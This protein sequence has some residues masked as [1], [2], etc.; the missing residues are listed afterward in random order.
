MKKTPTERFR[1]YTASAGA[2]K[3][4][5]LTVEY[6]T[7]A[8]RRPEYNYKRILAITFTKKATNEMNSRILNTCKAF[9]AYTRGVDGGV[10]SFMDCVMGKSGFSEAEIVKRS[11]VLYRKILHNYSDFA[12]NTIDSFCQRIIRSFA[13]ELDLPINFEVELDTSNA[14]KTLKDS[15][16]QRVGVDR[17]LTALIQGLFMTSLEEDDTTRI[18]Q[19][20]IDSGKLLLAEE[21][22]QRIGQFSQLTEKDMMDIRK[23]ISSKSE[24][25]LAH[26]KQIA[27]HALN[28]IGSYDLV[29]TDFKGGKTRSCMLWLTKLVEDN[30]TDFSEPARNQMLGS[31]EDWFAKKDLK[32]RPHLELKAEL[33]Q[34][35]IDLLDNIDAYNLVEVVR[36]NYTQMILIA[37]MYAMY[38]SYQRTETKVFINEF[39]QLI[40]N[41]VRNQP[42]PFIYEKIGEQYDYILIDEFQDTSVMQ[43]QNLVPLI[44][45]SLSRSED[46]ESLVVGDSKQ[47]IYRWKGGETQQLTM[48]PDLIGSEQNPYVQEHQSVLSRYYAS[49]PLAYNYRSS[50][51][52]VSFNN[53]LYEYIFNNGDLS[54]AQNIYESYHQKVHHTDKPGYVYVHLYEKPSTEEEKSE[55]ID[56]R[57]SDLVETIESVVARGYNYR[58]I[59][60]LSRYKNQLSIIAEFLREHGIRFVSEESLQMQNEPLI[61]TFIMLYEYYLNP[62]DKIKALELAS[63]L[64]RFGVIDVDTHM[65]N[66]TIGRSSLQK[67]LDY[68]DLIQKWNKE[69]DIE[70]VYSLSLLE[71]WEEYMSWIPEEHVSPVFAAFFREYLFSFVQNHGNDFEKLIEWW[72]KEGSE[73]CVKSSEGVDGVQLLTIHKSKGLEYDVVMLPFV[74]WKLKKDESV[75]LDT[76]DTSV[77][78]IISPIESV[79]IKLTKTMNLGPLHPRYV[80]EMGKVVIDNL[81]L[82]YVAT[83]RAVN[84]LYISGMEKGKNSNV[85]SM[86]E[87][88]VLIAEFIAVQGGQNSF[89]MG[90]PTYSEAKKK[91]GDPLLPLQ[92]DYERGEMAAISIK[93]RATTIWN[94]SVVDKISHGSIMHAL[95]EEIHDAQDVEKSI[96]QG[97]RYGWI[98]RD[99]AAM[100]IARLTEL[101][102]EPRVAAFFDREKEVLAERSILDASGKEYIPDRLLIE[103]ERV[104]IMDF[105][106]GQH[107]EKHNKQV[108]K[109]GE[110]LRTMGYTLGDLL[111]VYLDPLE[112]KSVGV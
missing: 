1:V 31:S 111:L 71:A 74:D 86:S 68:S 35:L 11:G 51:D 70:A 48:L 57:L 81:N 56:Q 15:L 44:T 100:Y 46:N 53:L 66:K 38:K 43:W 63:H 13:Y 26:A 55:L 102:Q 2:G 104:H 85:A 76:K 105:K 75:W 42:A 30:R 65:L 3:T 25:L 12:V 23:R 32:D 28:V 94:E 45:E 58:D 41:E 98:E 8:L 10:D 101:A 67:T 19:K 103:G 87:M 108:L 107:E 97:V 54:F 90:S 83:T 36:K 89:S 39:N 9:S 20:I 40:S 17:E 37:H 16:L 22:M 49:V 27:E 33:E 72:Q 112:I 88:S 21:S 62:Y 5:M 91:D 24:A 7:F 52:V 73:L 6:L 47:A 60:I 106:T 92:V 34:P 69:I 95:L 14:L 79:Y 77:E 109:Y 50:Q 59:A 61:R 99:D 110:V 78:E 29:P 93:S 82:L 18:D 4:F 80:E 96:E 64:N 84:E